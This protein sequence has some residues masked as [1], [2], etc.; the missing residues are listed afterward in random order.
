MIN[1]QAT[2]TDLQTQMPVLGGEHLACQMCIHVSGNVAHL[3][4]GLAFDHDRVATG[5]QA[6]R[7]LSAGLTQQERCGGLL[8]LHRRKRSAQIV[9]G[10]KV[11]QGDANQAKIG[12]TGRSQPLT[13]FGQHAPII[14]QAGGHVLAS[15]LRDAIQCAPTI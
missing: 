11:G 6:C 15:L 2:D 1:E 14:E 5:R 4:H 9:D 13:E 8:K 10:I 3:R 7:K 12:S